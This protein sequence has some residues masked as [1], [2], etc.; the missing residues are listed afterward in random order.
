MQGSRRSHF[1]GRAHPRRYVRIGRSAADH[2]IR[3]IAETIEHIFREESGRILAGLIR[4]S[5]SFDLAEE[6]V[7]DA[8]ASALE[9]WPRDGVPR[10]PGAWITTVAFRKLID[11]ARRE[12]RYAELDLSFPFEAPVATEE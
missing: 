9:I 6:A 4:R 12:K 11:R 2:G 8:F 7:Q 3:L 1:V 10:N 5:G